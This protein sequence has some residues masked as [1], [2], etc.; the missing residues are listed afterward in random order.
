M[1]K[2]AESDAAM[3]GLQLAFANHVCEFNPSRI[4]D[5][6][7]RLRRGAVAWI[8]EKVAANAALSEFI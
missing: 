5:G 6:S 2:T 3:H 7:N 1:N 4:L 8:D